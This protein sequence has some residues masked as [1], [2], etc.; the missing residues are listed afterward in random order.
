MGSI[1]KDV[2]PEVGVTVT[3]FIGSDRYPYVIT[4]VITPK[5]I[6]IARLDHE[7][8]EKNL[9][10]DENGV[11]RLNDNRISDYI[12]HAMDKVYTKRRN[13]RWVQDGDGQWAPGGI[14]IGHADHYLDPSF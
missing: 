13:G 7:D 8:Y 2:N 14:D 6:C 10:T 4:S 9:Y 11:Q 5:K 3:Y 12:A 1:G